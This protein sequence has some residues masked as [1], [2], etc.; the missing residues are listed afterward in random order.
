MKGKHLTS[1][2]QKSSVSFSVIAGKCGK[3]MVSAMVSGSN[4]P[5]SSLLR[6][7]YQSRHAKLLPRQAMCDDPNKG[8]R[9]CQERRCVTTLITA[10]KETISV[11]ALDGAI[12][13]LCL[14]LCLC[15][16]LSTDEQAAALKC[17]EVYVS[18]PSSS[19]HPYVQ[20]GIKEV[21]CSWGS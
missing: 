9:F 16:F 14:C 21:V 7:R 20:L 19:L 10:A 1:L 5:V 18:S 3:V 6:S 11:Q 17:M 2:R 12:A 13:C 15:C 4:G 8:K